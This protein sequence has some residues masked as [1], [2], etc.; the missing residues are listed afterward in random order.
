MPAAES[1]ERTAQDPV[2]LHGRRGDVLLYRGWNRVHQV[3]RPSQ[4]CS[5]RDSTVV[6]FDRL[7]R[8]FDDSR[9]DRRRREI[10]FL[11]LWFQVQ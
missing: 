9:A 11:R 6:D 3:D 7:I 5:L 1:G 4:V 10:C 2:D 8:Q